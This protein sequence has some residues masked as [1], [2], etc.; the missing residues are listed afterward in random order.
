MLMAASWCSGT[1]V[2]QD[3]LWI[4][5]AFEMLRG[6]VITLPRPTTHCHWLPKS[7]PGINT[8]M[9]VI[10]IICRPGGEVSWTRLR[11]VYD[12]MGFRNMDRRLLSAILEWIVSQPIGIVARCTHNNVW[13]LM[14]LFCAGIKNQRCKSNL[15]PVFC[16][17]HTYRT[18]IGHI[19]LLIRTIL[20][21]FARYIG[22]H[23]ASWRTNLVIAQHSF[24]FVDRLCVASYLWLWKIS[25]LASTMSHPLIFLFSFVPPFIW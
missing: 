20:Y 9:E 23:Y 8:S 1:C 2:V 10:I 24:T 21:I 14:C 11:P 25:P 22:C 4:S 15:K 7:F 5:P 19:I 13:Y 6:K 3:R 12:E 18:K 16:I 17:T